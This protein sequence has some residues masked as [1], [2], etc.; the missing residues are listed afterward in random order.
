[1][2][3]PLTTCARCQ[4]PITAKLV[5][6]RG[7]SFHPDCV[8]CAVCDEPLRGSFYLRGEDLV[9]HKEIKKI[10]KENKVRKTDGGIKALTAPWHRH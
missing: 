10:A 4:K 1:M 2:V 6:A 3:K 5:V 9:C 7:K 8:T